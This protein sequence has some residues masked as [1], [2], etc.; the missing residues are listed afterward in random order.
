MLDDMKQRIEQAHDDAKRHES[1]L[2]EF[3]L[4]ADVAQRA[5]VDAKRLQSELLQ[6]QRSLA[7]WVVEAV[8]RGR[9]QREARRGGPPAGRLRRHRDAAAVDG[10]GGARGGLAGGAAAGGARQTRRRRD[11]R[12]QARAPQRDAPRLAVLL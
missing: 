8:K 12:R 7:S 9:E 2:K 6:I 1:K 3:Q 11:H 5:A 4:E 10:R